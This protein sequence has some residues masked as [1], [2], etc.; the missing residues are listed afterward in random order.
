MC[1]VHAFA[2]MSCVLVCMNAYVCMGGCLRMHVMFMHIR[3]N[4]T[5]TGKHRMCVWYKIYSLCMV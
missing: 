1:S 5:R 2:R 4:S 3:L